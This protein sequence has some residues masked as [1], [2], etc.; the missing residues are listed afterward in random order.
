MPATPPAALP[1]P[2]DAPPARTGTGEGRR[3]V[4]HTRLRR[5]VQPRRHERGTQPRSTA[6]HTAELWPWPCP[7]GTPPSARC[8]RVE[9]PTDWSDPA[10]DTLTLPVV[11]IPAT[12]DD[13]R[14]D[15]LVVLTGGP[16]GS[17]TEV[18]EHWS[19]PHRDIVLCDQRGAGR[20]EP[21]SDCPERD[22]AWLANLQQDAGFTAERAALAD[23]TSSC[24]RRLE[25][26]G[27]DLDDYDTEASVRDLDAIRRTLGYSSGTSS[28]SATGLAWR[29]RRSA[30]PRRHPV[31]HPRLRERRDLRRPLGTPGID[32]TS[33]RPTPRRLC[34]ERR[35]SDG[36][37]RPP[38]R[39]RNRRT[40][41]RRDADCRRSS[42]G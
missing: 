29:S 41:V 8:T 3:R 26:S 28:A 19:D 39:D 21:R 12:T 30:R 32:R 38:G 6:A 17:I 16:G 20:A 10:A 25:A 14:P 22:S 13:R 24:R 33:T 37:P 4:R 35:L 27:I 42:G 7:V 15:A 1:R 18:A 34:P 2:D 9:V 36:A 40:A 11:V 23:A 31:R 5:G